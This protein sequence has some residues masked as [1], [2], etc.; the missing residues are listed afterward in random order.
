MTSRFGSR[1]HPLLG[2]VKAHQGVDYGAPVGTPVMAV[3]D[4][5]VTQAGSMGACG[6][7][8]VLRHQ[9]GLESVYCHLSSIAV[10]PGANVSQRQLVGLV[11]QT[12]AATGPH[13]HFALRRKGVF[14]NPL[15][16][17]TPRELPLAAG[18]LADFLAR[19]APLRA[20]LEAFPVAGGA[21]IARGPR[22]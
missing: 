10:Q 6:K 12:G 3:G 16:R 2:Y 11:G 7:T 1:L 15:T 4:G 5:T 9:D 20:Q 14:V 18:Q 17:K 22:G 19:S 21:A 8:V 13:L